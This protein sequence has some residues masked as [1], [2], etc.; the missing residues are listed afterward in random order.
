MR[1]GACFFLSATLLALVAAGAWRISR[2][3]RLS[4]ARR[5]RLVNGALLLLGV[6]GPLVAA[7][8]WFLFYYDATDGALSTLTSRRW[9]ERHLPQPLGT[10]RGRRAPSGDA[11]QAPPVVIGVL[12]DSLTYGQGIERDQDLY[13]SVLE[14]EL[15]ARGVAA[16]VF[17]ISFPGWDTREELAEL[18]RQFA[19]GG[20]FSL[21]VL[22]F[23][24]ND[25][26]PFVRQ[27]AGYQ[28]AV[29]GLGK[30][31]AAL[32]WLI[33]RSFVASFLYNHW[34]FLTS[35]TLSDAWRDTMF[36]GYRSPA[37]FRA[38]AE[39]LEAVRKLTSSYGVPLIALTFPDL[40]TPLDRYP[41]RDI[42]QRLDGLWKR[43]GV[44][45]VDLLPALERHPTSALRA[46]LM[47]GHPNELAHRIAGGQLAD[48][49]MLMGG[50][51]VPG[52]QAP[53]P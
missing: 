8:G 30:P 23:C 6:L 2:S 5:R 40:G 31:P 3:R 16:D 36:E 9:I 46:S 27:P 52:A 22:G 24:L 14:R 49:V 18:Q 15:R 7:E 37:S 32:A 44:P 33:T 26:A 25:I 47:D 48:A 50:R 53:S 38:L 42:H 11:D 17:N 28:A 43:L 10:P 13:S 45:H 35:S 41:N 21:V 29:A 51:S 4:P 12:G 34:V 1:Y 39:Q 19:G 20:K